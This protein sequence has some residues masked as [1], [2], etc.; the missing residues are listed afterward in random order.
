[1]S[2]GRGSKGQIGN[3]AFSPDGRSIV[4]WSV[5]DDT[6]KRIALDGGTPVTV[7]RGFQGGSTISWGQEG[8]VF[9]QIGAGILRV[10]ADGGTPE[11]LVMVN[12]SE[13]AAGPP[14]LP[15]ARAVLVPLPTGKRDGGRDSR[16]E[17]AKIVVQSLK[18][19][20]RKT[21]IDGRDGRYLPSGHLVYAVGGIVYAV[22]FDLQQLTVAGRA[23]PVIDGVRRLAGPG[24][25]DL[26]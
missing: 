17:K 22:P 2:P 8:I 5:S 14:V 6:I 16:W 9:G 10:P 12:E 4:F 3:L 19:G 20:E 11:Q 18:T 1:W 23:V 13:A 26:S 7:Y 25:A 15:G 21:L 24:A